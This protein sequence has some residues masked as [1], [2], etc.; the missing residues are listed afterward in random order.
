[1]DNVLE[2]K[3]KRF[4]QA[5]KIGNGGGTSMNGK[6]I[7]TSELLFR[8]KKKICQIKEFWEQE[9]RPFEGI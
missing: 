6:K 3:G 4:V 8:L 1:M 9:R 5:S 7:V 2:L